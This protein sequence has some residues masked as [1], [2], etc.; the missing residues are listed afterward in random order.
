MQEC[1]I[2]NYPV[3]HDS[4][5]KKRIKEE[6]RSHPESNIPPSSE[7]AWSSAVHFFELLGP[8]KTARLSCLY[9]RRNYDE[10]GA[11]GYWR[12]KVNPTRAAAFSN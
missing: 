6:Q 9:P 8:S 7:C 5:F 2:E 12:C 4:T 10:A 11:V 1:R 3:G